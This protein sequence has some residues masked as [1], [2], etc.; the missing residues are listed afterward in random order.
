MTAAAEGREQFIQD[1]YKG[2]QGGRSEPVQ[3]TARIAG[4]AGSCRRS[5]NRQTGYCHSRNCHSGEENKSQDGEKSTD[6]F[7]GSEPFPH[8]HGGISVGLEE[9][10]P[11]DPYGRSGEHQP[12]KGGAGNRLDTGVFPVLPEP[13]KAQE[14]ERPQDSP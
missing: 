9:Q 4:R 14:K 11:V 8:G 12:E 13:E 2:I 10:D 5:G 1:D 6:Q 3:D 7:F